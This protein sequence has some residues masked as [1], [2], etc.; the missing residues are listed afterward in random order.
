MSHVY[1][2]G[3]APAFAGCAAGD[4]IGTAAGGACRLRSSREARLSAFGK[5][6]QGAALML[7][8]T[9]LLSRMSIAPQLAVQV[10]LLG[11][12]LI[13][14][15][16]A[17]MI[18]AVAALTSHVTV[19]GDG[20]R[21]RLG[22]AAFNI[23]WTDVTRWRVSDHDGRLPAIACAEVWLRGRHQPR[24]LPGGFLDREARRQLRKS[25]RTFAPEQEG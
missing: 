9:F 3:L 2:G 15:G 13:G 8:G 1:D 18:L 6:I 7:T 12:L 17:F 16:C 19:D 14:G 11:T 25:C 24:S 21:G 20:V 22:S 4:E 10:V 5:G 23:A